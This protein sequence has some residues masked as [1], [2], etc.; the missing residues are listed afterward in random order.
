MF[1]WPD[2]DSLT[3][4]SVIDMLDIKFDMSPNVGWV[5]ESPGVYSLK[6]LL[7]V[8]CYMAGGH[9]CHTF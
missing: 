1:V 8:R 3:V 5:F 6:P 7:K 9:R 2:E 4:F